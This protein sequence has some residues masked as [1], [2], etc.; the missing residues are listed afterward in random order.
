MV[1]NLKGIISTIIAS[2]S[3]TAIGV[4]AKAIIDVRVLKAQR[5][6]DVNKIKNNHQAIIRNGGKI[7]NLKTE[8]ND[9]FKTVIKLLK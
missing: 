1:K 8:M 7:D 6:E 5:V 9:N 2:V 4:S 3:V